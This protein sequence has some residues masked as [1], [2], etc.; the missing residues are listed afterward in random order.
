MRVQLRT[1]TKATP[2]LFAS[3]PTRILQRKCACGGTPG[4]SGECEECRKKKLQRKTRNSELE[5]R[6]DSE[7]PTIVHEVLRSPGQPLD[8][9]TLAFMEPRF[10]HDFS[11]VRVHTDAK[12]MESARAVNALAYTVG[13]N[14]VFSAEAYSP[15]SRTGQQLIAHELTHVIQQANGAVSGR[16]IACGMSVSDPGDAYERQADVVASGLFSGAASSNRVPGR[17]AYLEPLASGL[18]HTIQRQPRRGRPAQ[19]ASRGPAV[20][21]DHQGVSAGQMHRSEFLTTLREALFEATDAEFR[22][23]G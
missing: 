13:R 3:V 23:F 10:G 9:A 7:V 1:V 16:P 14:V 8:P 22:R 11:S 4:P 5:T 2:A 17:S 20:V 21:E 18:N 6:N 12:A 15:Y 19:S